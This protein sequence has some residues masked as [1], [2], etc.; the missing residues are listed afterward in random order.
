VNGVDG[1]ADDGCKSRFNEERT[2]HD[3]EHS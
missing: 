1:S 2:A 3:H